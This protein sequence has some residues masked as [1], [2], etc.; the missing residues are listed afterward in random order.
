MTEINGKWSWMMDYCKKNH[1]P[2][3][4]EWAWEK[5]KVAY[6]KHLES[7]RSLSKHTPER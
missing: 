1:L 2:P 3:A 6:L 7:L 4:Q 5:A